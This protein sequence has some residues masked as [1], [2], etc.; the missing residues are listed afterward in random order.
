TSY[1]ENI[2]VLAMTKGP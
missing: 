1:G 2:G